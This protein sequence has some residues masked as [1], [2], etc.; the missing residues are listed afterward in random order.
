MPNIERLTQ[1]RRVVEAAPDNLIYTRSVVEEGDTARCAFGWAL[2]EPWFIAN[3]DKKGCFSFIDISTWCTAARFDLCEE[4]ANNLFGVDPWFLTN[5]NISSLAGRRY[6]NID[7]MYMD[8]AG[9][10]KLFDLSE[11]DADNLFGAD[12]L[13]M[14]GPHAVSRQEVLDN[15][16]RLLAGEPAWQ[17]DA[18][19]EDEDACDD[20]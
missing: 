1:L 18:V 17:Y 14:V 8:F 7:E 2:V 12:F 13:A 16:D 4:D 10:Q 15:I 3:T 11:E 6:G 9:V 5:T 19:R 20:E